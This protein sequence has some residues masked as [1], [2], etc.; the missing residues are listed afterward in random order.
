[1]AR[2]HIIV[3]GRVQGVGFRY[4]SYLLADACHLTGWVQNLD[5][6]DVEL[7][8]QGR[9]EDIDK[10]LS[11]LGKRS[12]FIQIDRMKLEDMEDIR[13]SDFTIKN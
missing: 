9:I 12:W 2:K 6:G 4:H 7:E 13:E 8:I 10:F 3:S 1:M 11:Q 5:S